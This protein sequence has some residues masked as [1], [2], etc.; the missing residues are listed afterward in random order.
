MDWA[1]HCLWNSTER[2]LR[3]T[4]LCFAYQYYAIHVHVPVSKTSNDDGRRLHGV[5]QQQHAK[6][7][8]RSPVVVPHTPRGVAFA[9][10]HLRVC[11]VE[12]VVELEQHA[13]AGVPET[14]QIAAERGV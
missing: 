3:R 7:Q 5:Q 8:R 12:S 11:L 2:T 14:G 13:V 10:Q 6:G 9:L 4:L 1:L